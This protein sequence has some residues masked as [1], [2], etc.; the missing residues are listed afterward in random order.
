M[1]QMNHRQGR[2]TN[3]NNITPFVQGNTVR[4]VE[5]VEEQQTLSR[6]ERIRLRQN[7]E[8]HK[9]MNLSYVLIMGT[10]LLFVAVLLC[11]YIQLQSEV[12]NKVKEIS[13]LEVEY[14][15]LKLAND[16]ELARINSSVD[17]EEIKAIAIGELGMTYAGEGQI[18]TIEDNDQD[19]VHQVADLP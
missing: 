7:R 2:R 16:E 13:K 19:Y 1:N 18:V 9:R 3:Y 10:A 15:R 12:T 17:L 6:D 11:N 14:N 4:R 8:R 5:V